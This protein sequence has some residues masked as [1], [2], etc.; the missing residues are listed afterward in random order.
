MK[1]TGNLINKIAEMENLYL[2]WVKAKRGK[3]KKTD[4]IAFEKSLD[5]NLKYMQ[6]QLLSNK[7]DVGNYHYFTITDPKTRQICA[8]SF[9]ERVL[10]HAIMNVCEQNFEQHLIYDTYAT[11]K[12]KGTYAALNRAKHFTKKYNY[13]VKLDIRKYFD[14]IDHQIL[15]NQLDAKF[16]DKQLLSVFYKIINSYR[17]E[18][19]R[20]VPIGNLTSQ[21]FANHYLSVADHFAKEHLKVCA[22]VRYMDDMLLFGNNKDKLLKK[23]QDFIYFVQANLK[24]NFKPIIHANTMGGVSC[25]GYKLYPYSVKLNKRSKS[26]FKTKLNNYEENLDTG[27]WN[28]W[29]YQQ[30]ILPLL[31]FVEYGDTLNFRKNVI[32]NIK[33]KS[34]RH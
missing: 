4:V 34:R 27:K 8:A 25:L 21:Y 5:V 13:Y 32:R 15:K 12:N 20:G 2:A 3:S 33:G 30:H 9:P 19:N 24:L 7:V 29:Q 23:M 16:K 31:A 26:R 17:V 6:S 18:P 11:R 22:Y 1:R 10:H 28:Q 14:S